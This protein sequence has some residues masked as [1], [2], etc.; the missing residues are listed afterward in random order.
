[1]VRPFIFVAPSDGYIALTSISTVPLN[2]N[3]N[4]GNSYASLFS[5]AYS[6]DSAYFVAFKEA[7]SWPVTDKMSQTK[8][9]GTNTNPRQ[10]Q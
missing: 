4:P 3:P 2:A 7:M 10:N 6:R 8:Y 1:M 5:K 9:K